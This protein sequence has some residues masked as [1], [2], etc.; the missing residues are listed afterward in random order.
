M[1]ALPILQAHLARHADDPQAWFL[2][3]ACK[4]ALGDLP[5]ALDAF[6]RSIGLSPPTAEPYLALATV[7]SNA[8]N[9]DAALRACQQGLQR[10]ASEHRLHHASG[11]ALERLDRHDEALAEYKRALALAPLTE[12]ILHNY[13]SLLARL[14]RLEQAES[15]YR[16]YLKTHPASDT[17][18]NGLADILLAQGR[19][20]ETLELLEPGSD[21]ALILVRRGFALAA[22]RRFAEAHKA[23][24]LA[25]AADA[26]SV[27]RFVRRVAPGADADL[28]LSPENVFMERAYAA[29]CKCDWS[30]WDAMIDEARQAGANADVALEPAVGFMIRFLPLSGA[31]RHAVLK[32][33]ADR[34]EARTPS[35]APR[36]ASGRPRIRVGVLSPDFRD[37]LNADL[38]LPLFE[39][40]DRE[41]FEA[42]AYSLAPDDGSSSRARIRSAADAFRDLHA[43]SD[44]E[45]AGV[46]RRDGIDVLVDVAGHTTGGRFGIV[47]RRPAPVQVNY[48]GFSCSLGST[49]VDYAI[50]DRRAAPS[51]AEWSESLAY[52]PDSFFLYDY[53]GRV[54]ETTASRRDYGLP[55]RAFVFCAFHRAEKIAPDVFDRWMEI[56]QRVPRSILW[57]LA[58]P[59]AAVGNLYRHASARGIDASRLIFAPF[60]PRYGPRYLPRQRLGDLFLDAFHH[61][62]TTTACDALGV[63]LPLLTLRGSAVAARIATS[64]LHAA[65]LPE[66]VA[67]D[68]RD[69]VAKAVQLATDASLLKEYRQR[70]VR[71]RESA[72]LFDTASLVR[73]LEAAFERM[74]ARA[75]SG[76]PPASFDVYVSAHIRSR[77]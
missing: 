64:L 21:D 63:G 42:Y 75:Q 55:E 53:R 24:A 15:H 70:L 1:L 9:A 8:G 33:I 57:L 35:M 37:H 26:S 38:L 71:N 6:S 18:R 13:G 59:P 76:Q 45:A 31:E 56:L 50:V 41:R 34:I 69:F 77:L 62:A 47:A 60:E 54:P 58:Q 22:Q 2:F 61:T 20:D 46:I 66:L 17:A 32:R 52:M 14:G 5:G 10:F 65:G 19:Y 73:G 44:D 48:L 27:E 23:F 4:H 12:D 3:G 16:S 51:A 7:A 25:R 72:P 74:H 40:M 39:L 43:A 11:V 30:K 29:I 67:T 68:S 28:M 49:R 36:P